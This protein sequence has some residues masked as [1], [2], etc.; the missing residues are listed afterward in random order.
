VL[1]S[2]SAG[3]EPLDRGA[4]W[5]QGG[6]RAGGRGGLCCSEEG[7]DLDLQGWR[8]MEPHWPSALPRH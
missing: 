5:E 2:G 8:G 6:R 4:R 1:T 7:N 3:L